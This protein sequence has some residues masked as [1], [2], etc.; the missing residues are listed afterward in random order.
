MV[1]I[2]L[3][4]FLKENKD[5]RRI[6]GKKEIE[7]ILKQLE[8]LKLTQSE[9]NRLSRDIRPKLEV[10]RKMADYSNEFDLK[11]NQNNKGIINKAIEII[12]NDQLKDKIQAILLF[13]SFA[14]KTYTFRSDI[15]IC[16][17]FKQISLEEATKFRVRVSGIVP[18]KIDL[19]VFNV[20]P[21]KL[22]KDIARNHKILYHSD[23]FDNI[24]FS[25][26]YLKCDD[27]FLRMK[28]VFEGAEA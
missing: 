14:D 19:Q 20:L 17:L 18:Q 25:I 7:I 1:I 10:I 11:K 8:G 6:F 23:D 12:L 28:R 21:M 26:R 9:M 3:K 2:L 27:Y 15:D 5:A 13:G 4:E 24:E 16:V 22:K